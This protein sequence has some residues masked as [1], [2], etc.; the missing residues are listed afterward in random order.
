MLKR[1]ECHLCGQRFDSVMD[2][3]YR[4]PEGNL[5]CL[6]CGEAENAWFEWRE[7]EQEASR[8]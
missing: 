7:R 8:G 2:D 6:E 4:D 3:Y 5:L 1:T